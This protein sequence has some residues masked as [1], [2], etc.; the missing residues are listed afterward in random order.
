MHSGDLDIDHL[1]GE[2]LEVNQRRSTELSQIANN[3]F[4][5]HIRLFPSVLYTRGFPASFVAIR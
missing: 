3:R 5:H 2:K 4:E 1:I